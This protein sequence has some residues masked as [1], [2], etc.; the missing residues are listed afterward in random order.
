MNAPDLTGHLPLSPATFAV[1]AAL[2]RGPRTGVEMLDAID[3]TGISILG[4]GTLYRILRELRAAGWIERVPDPGSGEGVDERRRHHALTETG[5][6]VLGL[7]AQRLRR[8]L[9]QMGRLGADQAG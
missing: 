2:A 7:E 3:G 8:T 4:P 5:G 6:T 1:M 9:A